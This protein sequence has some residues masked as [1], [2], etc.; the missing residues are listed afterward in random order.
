[1]KDLFYK[2]S[3]TVVTALASI[4]AYFLRRVHKQI[5]DTRK[6]VEALDL[7]MAKIKLTSSE[8]EEELIELK[9]EIHSTSTEFRDKNKNLELKLEEIGHSI[10][11]QNGVLLAIAHKLEIGSMVKNILD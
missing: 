7:E 4:I 11:K 5:D 9:A 1:M 8:H 2:T 10:I 3:I 6:K